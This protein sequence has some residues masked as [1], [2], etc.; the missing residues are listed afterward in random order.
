MNAKLTHIMLKHL[1]NSRTPL[2]KHFQLRN[3]SN[4]LRGSGGSLLKDDDFLPEFEEKELAHQQKLDSSIVVT[5]RPDD[6]LK[7][8]EEY[9]GIIYKY[10]LPVENRPIELRS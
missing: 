5:K 3:F 1:N 7:H 4:L 9:G 2:I 10:D 8:N 6:M